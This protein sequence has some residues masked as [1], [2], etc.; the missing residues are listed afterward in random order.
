MGGAG[1]AAVEGAEALYWNPARLGENRRFDLEAYYAKWFADLRHQFIG[2][3]VPVGSDFAL[4]AFALSLGGDE[5]EQTTLSAQEGN[6]VMVGYGDLALGVSLAYRMTDR[7]SAGGTIKYLHQKLFSEVASTFAVDL[8]TSLRTDLPGFSIG[9]AMTNLGGEM[10]LEGRDLITGGSGNAPTQYEVSGWPLPLSFQVGTAWRLIGTREAL[11]KDPDQDFLL[12]FDGQ[13]INEGLTRWR[14]GGEYGFKQT[15][16]LRGGWVLGHDTE[17]WSA[18]AGLAAPLLSYR[19]EVNFA[20]A[21]L[22]D[23][24]G[25]QRLSVRLTGR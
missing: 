25:V 18:G 16:F 2:L 6:G 1:I 5:F 20:Y 3:S 14:I 22:G 19:V 10:K 13:H 17:T 8:G 12:C 7:F 21:D 23:L 24:K 15:L 9:M 11:R 4:G